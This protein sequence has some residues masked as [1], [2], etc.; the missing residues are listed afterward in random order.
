M[1]PKKGWS[2]KGTRCVIKKSKGGRTNYSGCFLISSEGVEHWEIKK[3]S[4]KSDDLLKF[5][6]NSNEDILKGKTLVLDNARTHHKKEVKDKLTNLEIIGKYLPP[7]SPELNPIEEVFGWL[8]T[9]LRRMK[10]RKEDELKNGI[11]LLVK[12]IREK[13]IL[14]RFKHSYD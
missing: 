2:R 5:F 1:D 11:E 8:K 7:Y 3:G 12:K 14:E 4:V 6:G 10:I 9:E 13:G